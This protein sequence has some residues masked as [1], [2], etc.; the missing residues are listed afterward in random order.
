MSLTLVTEISYGQRFD[1]LDKADDD[2]LAAVFF[3]MRQCRAY[4]L[5]SNIYRTSCVYKHH[6][7]YK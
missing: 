6:V 5:Q 7:Y 4:I 2:E 1:F 3:I